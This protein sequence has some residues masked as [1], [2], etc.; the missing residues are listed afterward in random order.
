MFRDIDTKQIVENYLYRL[1]QTSSII[2]YTTEFQKYT[3]YTGQDTEA[4]IS[5]Y[6]RRLKSYIQLELARI[7]VQ[8][9]NIVSLVEYTIRIDNC[10]QE[11]F[12]GNHK[13]KQSNLYY[14][15]KVRFI[16]AQENRQSDL[17]ELDTIDYRKKPS[18]EE[19]D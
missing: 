14:N 16:L 11:F 15:K 18:K 10:L 8:S 5:Y 1:K 6:K 4:L 7:E 17:I 19:I 12:I 13:K 9:S 2:Q 3:N